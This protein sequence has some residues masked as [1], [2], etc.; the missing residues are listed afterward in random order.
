MAKKRAKCFCEQI[1]RAENPCMILWC[2][3]KAPVIISNKNI[4]DQNKINLVIFN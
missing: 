3:R 2:L 4:I 1:D